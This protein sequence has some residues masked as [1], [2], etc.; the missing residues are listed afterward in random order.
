ML[1]AI[2]V[3][4]GIAGL[5]AG[6]ALRRAGHRV[7]IYERSSMNNEIGAAI[8]LPPNASRFLVGW[9]LDPDAAGFVL[10]KSVEFKD[11]VTLEFL[12]GHSHESMEEMYGAAL[13]FAHRVDLHDALKKMA[14]DPTAPGTPV[15]IHL[16]AD[17]IGYV[18]AWTT[19]GDL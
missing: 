1:Q 8:H 13:W 11:P 17:V 4:A 18:G 5:S 7:L 19:E 14:L 9:G 2:V 3:G 16:N 12:S 10:A 6:I 15:E